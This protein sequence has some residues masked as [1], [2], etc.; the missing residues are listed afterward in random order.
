MCHH[1]VDALST[2]VFVA[3]LVLGAFRSLVPFQNRWV[4]FPFPHTRTHT[5]ARTRAHTHT[6]THIRT[7]KYKHTHTEQDTCAAER[8]R[9][10]EEGGAV[11]TRTNSFGPSY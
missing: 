3:S 9:R 1:P 2:I 5:H 10:E 8:D 7:H 6:Q 4:R 11:D